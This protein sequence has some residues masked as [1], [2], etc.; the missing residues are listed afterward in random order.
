[1]LPIVAT[2]TTIQKFQGARSAA[3]SA[4]GP[5]RGSPRTGGSAP[6]AA[7]SSPIRSPSRAHAEV[8]DRPVERLQERDDDLVD[9]R[10]HGP[11]AA[12]WWVA[13]RSLVAAPATRTPGRIADYPRRRDRRPLRTRA[14]PPPRASG[15]SSSS[16]APTC[17]SPTSRRSPAAAPAALDV[18]A[19][20]DAGGARGHRE[21]RRRGRGRLRGDDRVRRPR[22]DLHPAR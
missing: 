12:R 3:R 11:V 5:R 8:A 9:E 17:P 7:E 6:M 22:H 18:H 16:P 2:T 4:R 10:E 20:A 15:D 21:A 1:M 13:D 14:I 19:R